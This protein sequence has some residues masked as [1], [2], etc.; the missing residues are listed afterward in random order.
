MNTE[1]STERSSL[2]QF[3]GR[4][5]DSGRRPLLFWIGIAAAVLVVLFLIFRIFHSSGQKYATAIIE[6]GDMIVHVTA[7]G[8]LQPTNEVTVGSQVSGLIDK[9][10][11]DINDR[12][13]KN[14]I[15]AQINTDTLQ[16]AVQRSQAALAQ[17]K[18]SV[19]LAQAQVDQ[20]K[21]QFARQQEVFKLSGGKIPSKTDLDTARATY[22]GNV[23]TLASNRAS[24]LSAQA[25][26]KTDE[27]NLGFATIRSP[28]EGVVL[29]RQVEPGQTVAAS[30]STPTLFIIAQDLTQMKLEVK[31]DEADVGQVKEG[32]TASFAVDAYPGKTFDAR[33][34]RVDVGSNATTSDSTSTSSST[35]T[36]SSSSDVVS[37]GAVLTVNNRDL[38][39][40]PGMTAIANIVTNDE[41]N[42]LMVPNAALRYQPSQATSRRGFSLFGP[43]TKSQQQVGIG[44]GSSQ[45]MYVLQGADL[46]PVS[47][48]VG[49]T[50]GTN[51]IVSG[52]E[53]Q[54]GMKVVTG[55]LA[56]AQ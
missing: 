3:L 40:R 23:A 48:R 26:L 42:V 25:Q 55:E 29:S 28:V 49:D 41:K 36:T 27:T 50:D 34:T 24:V 20:S 9:V 51:T 47:V 31:V 46:K 12:V 35:A 4:D 52:P 11:V 44:R 14:E 13:R 54:P 19:D 37:Y 30:F 38:T 33:I 53:L 18:A 39:L 45:T 16:A 7:T 43:I 8:N 1:A 5:P 22:Q 10:F 32:Q 2:D 15:L 56:Q 17:A 6:R 21:A